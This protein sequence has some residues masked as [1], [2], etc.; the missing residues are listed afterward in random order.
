MFL[1][2]QAPNSTIDPSSSGWSNL[3]IPYKSLNTA[4]SYNHSSENEIDI[5]TSEEENIRVTEENKPEVK[6]KNPYSIEELLK[7]PTKRP[8]PLQVSSVGISQPFG[9][10][11]NNSDT[12]CY[13]A[14]VNSNYIQDEEVKL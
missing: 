12:E 8:K 9:I 3:V 7:K 2:P 11:L 4:D 14:N 5:V 6:K 1:Q 13:K 10:V